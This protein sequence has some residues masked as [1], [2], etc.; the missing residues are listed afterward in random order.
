M[1]PSKE[2]KKKSEKKKKA[3]ASPFLLPLRWKP[4]KRV[5]SRGRGIAV[6][7]KPHSCVLPNCLRFARDLSPKTGGSASNG[8]EAT[9]STTNYVRVLGRAQEGLFCNIEVSEQVS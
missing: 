9:N 6:L 8:C 4:S 7:I 1:Y 2:E 3:I 5:G